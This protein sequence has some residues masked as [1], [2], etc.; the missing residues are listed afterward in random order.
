MGMNESGV[1][2]FGTYCRIRVFESH[3]NLLE[4]ALR[5]QSHRHRPH[6]HL[7]QHAYQVVW[8][9]GEK[10]G[11]T[12]GDQFQSAESNRTRKPGI[13]STCTFLK[14]GIPRNDSA[15]RLAPLEPIFVPDTDK[16]VR[17]SGN[18]DEQ[19]TRRNKARERGG[20]TQASSICRE[21]E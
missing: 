19:A 3:K 12:R 17:E 8:P 6:S 15:S 16:N 18:Q 21:L 13:P 5:R 20:E 7:F 4:V 2:V 10:I 11:E 9:V 14:V 1:S